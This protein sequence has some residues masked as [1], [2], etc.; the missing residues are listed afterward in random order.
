M[1]DVSWSY[2]NLEVFSTGLTIDEFGDI[3]LDPLAQQI[4]VNSIQDG[5]TFYTI[6]VRFPNMEEIF[7]EDLICSEMFFNTEVKHLYYICPPKIKG[8]YLPAITVFNQ[9]MVK[10]YKCDRPLTGF[11]SRQ[12]YIYKHG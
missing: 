8:A 12:S 9:E 7:M 4:N 6:T 3:D 5:E 1:S 10:Y 2:L 11:I